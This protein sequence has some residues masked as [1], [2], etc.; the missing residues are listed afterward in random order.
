[1]NEGEKTSERPH[2]YLNVAHFGG[3]A[4]E[5]SAHH[6][7]EDVVGEVGSSEAT[8]DKLGRARGLYLDYYYFYVFAFFCTSNETEFW[9][10]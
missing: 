1:V 10:K 9:T 3:G 8:L 7:G 5:G 2:L 4:D 6:G